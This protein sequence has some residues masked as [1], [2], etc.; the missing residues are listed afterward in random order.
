M[1][2]LQCDDCGYFLY[3]KIDKTLLESDFIQKQ[4][5]IHRDWKFIFGDLIV[6]A[7]HYFQNP[8]RI[9]NQIA[10][11]LLFLTTPKKGTV[12]YKKHPFF[13]PSQARRLLNLARNKIEDERLSLSFILNTLRNLNLELTDVFFQQIPFSFYKFLKKKEKVKNEIIT[14]CESHWCR[15]Y[16]TS[17]AM[18]DM[19]A[20]SKGKYVPNSHL[21]NP[22]LVCTNCCVQRG[23]HKIN[24]QWERINISYKLLN[25]IKELLDSGLSLRQIGLRLKID[26]YRIKYYLGYIARFLQDDIKDLDKK[27][28]N[29]ETL[30]KNF[31]ELKPYWRSHQM[32]AKK[33]VNLFNWNAVTTY[34]YFWHPVIQEYIYFEQNQRKI[35]Q[36]I[37]QS[38]VHE[39]DDAIESLIKSDK[40]LSVK[41]VAAT[42]NITE[43]ELRYHN[44]NKEI[45]N[46]KYSKVSLDKN[47]EK[48]TIIEYIVAFINNKK[49]SEQQI[50]AHEIYKSI[51]RSPNYIKRNFPD[52]AEQISNLVKESKSKQKEIRRMNLVRVIIEIYKEYGEVDM[53]LLSQNLGISVKTLKTGQGIYK[54]L[55]QLI[56]KTIA[57][58]QE[59]Q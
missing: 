9:H 35:N 21:Y 57:E 45:I 12:N 23:F 46:K 15:Y 4:L 51:G 42:L 17:N 25:E 22:V 6:K 26:K 33:A 16:G 11:L 32:L 7:N 48:A 34:Y 14:N 55:G 36:S 52:I 50:F 58:F 39:M 44:L 56:R 49:D 53:I 20:S 24:K 18:K 8:Q 5:R 37:Y 19:G 41:E 43:A 59:N 10:I 47:E 29:I 1:D 27:I 31:T 2:Q 38:L 54:G 30:I 28:I 3:D 40:K 13:K